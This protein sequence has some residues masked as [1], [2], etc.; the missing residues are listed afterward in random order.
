MQM[1]YP[2]HFV[3]K[4]KFRLKNPSPDGAEI[5]SHYRTKGFV[6]KEHYLLP[7]PCL[8]ALQLSNAVKWIREK[9]ALQTN[10]SPG[11]GTRFKAHAWLEVMGTVVSSLG[12]K[13]QA[14]GW[15]FLSNLHLE[16]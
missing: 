14:R 8:H 6:C 13:T 2:D 10:D 16:Y 5:N 3:S 12:V 9:A 15:L 1:V 11:R 7:T 4:L